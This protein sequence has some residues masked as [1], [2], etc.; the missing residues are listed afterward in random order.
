M[1]EQA[2]LRVTYWLTI[3]AAIA[4]FVL[5]AVE[6]AEGLLDWEAPASITFWL[7]MA[8]G[9]LA[10][11]ESVRRAREIK[12]KPRNDR[13][14]SDIQK[15]LSSAVG[16]ISDQTGVSIQRLGANAFRVKQVSGVRRWLF[17]AEPR[18]ER[19]YRYRIDDHPAAS[20]VAWTMGKGT[21]GR[22]WEEGRKAHTDWRQIARRWQDKS[23]SE[24]Q[25][26]EIP[27]KTRH[28]FSREEFMAVVGKYAE[29][30]AV[31]IKDEHGE[32]LGCV[33]V[34]IPLDSDPKRHDVLIGATVEHVLTAAASTI[35]RR[36]V[37]D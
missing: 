11:G 4:A 36:L 33:A 14:R 24:E 31:P 32:V 30:V 28:K 34:D 8:V 2:K 6:S 16:I 26:Q 12:A 37:G 18:L 13:F 3:L 35:A 5:L 27:E 25:F 19:L 1:S 17:K 15:A 9:A 20:K 23:L 7:T 21:I 22:A 10:L 29:V